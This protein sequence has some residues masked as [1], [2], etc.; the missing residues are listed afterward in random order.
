MDISKE[1]QD[2]KNAINMGR[3]DGRQKGIE[4]AFKSLE[5]AVMEFSEPKLSWRVLF[6]KGFMR[7]FKRS[8]NKWK[9]AIYEL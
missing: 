1:F 2:L 4:K 7:G 6:K 5:K 3:V 9:G 8:Y